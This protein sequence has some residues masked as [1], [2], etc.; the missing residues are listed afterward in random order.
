MTSPVTK[1]NIWM[2]PKYLINNGLNLHDRRVWRIIRANE[3]GIGCILSNTNIAIRILS[4]AY[5]IQ[6]SIHRLQKVNALVSRKSLMFKCVL[7][8]KQPPLQT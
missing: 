1:P 3:K 5:D 6:L 7:R 2:H 4:S 8:T